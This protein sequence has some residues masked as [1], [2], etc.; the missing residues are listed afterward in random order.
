[1]S[2]VV[3]FHM[4]IYPGFS[5]GK[6]LLNFF[7]NVREQ[8]P[9][10]NNL[11]KIACLAERRDLN[12]FRKLASGDRSILPEGWK[13]KTTLDGLAVQIFNENDS[14]YFVCGR[15]IITKERLE[16]L[17]ISLDITIEDGLPALEVIDKVYEQG[18]IP[19][20]AWAPGKWAFSRGKIV[21]KI[22]DL[23]IDSKRLCIGDSS[24]RPALYDGGQYFKKA[25]KTGFSI[26]PGSDPLPFKGEEIRSGLNT[27]LVDIPGINPGSELRE[28][29]MQNGKVGT[30]SFKASIFKVFYRLLMHEVSKKIPKHLGA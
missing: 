24:L 9:D 22:I 21:N 12:I 1:M 27:A 8:Y 25:E 2:A 14:I 4:H 19:V 30:S 18:G 5:L 6:I 16:I 26:L 15:Q 3:D 29:I 23:N 13:L 7:K 28:F 11:V 17:S 20:L 10:K